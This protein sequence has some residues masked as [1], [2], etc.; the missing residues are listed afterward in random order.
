MFQ[1]LVSKLGGLL[2]RRIYH[3]PFSRALTL[4]ASQADIIGEIYQECMT[5]R[6][7]MLV[8]PE[9]ILSFKLMGIEC[10]LNGQPD[11]GR[12]LLRTQHFFDN[13]SRD[14]VDESDENFSVKFE[15]VYTMGE[16][17]GRLI[18]APLA[19]PTW[20]DSSRSGVSYLQHYEFL[21]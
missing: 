10:L 13:K 11:V 1:M 6:G 20:K 8:Q 5:N 16:Y 18:P 14:I 2:N 21:C 19:A 9:H 12:S 17:N 3:M 7:I 15:L 4:S